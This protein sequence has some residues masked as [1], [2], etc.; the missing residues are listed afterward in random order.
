MRVLLR[1]LIAIALLTSVASLVACSSGPQFKYES[2]R[3][4]KPL[5]DK[6]APLYPAVSFLVFS[7]LHIY[8]ATL[9]IEGQAFED[10]LADD[11]KLL[12]ESL[13]I[14]ESA[15][16]AMKAE[17]ADFVIVPGDLSKD[18]ELVSHETCATYLDSLEASG[19]QVFVVPGNHDIWNGNAVRYT[20]NQTER[21]PS[22]SP[23]DF[24]RIYGAYGYNEALY[25]DTASL[26]Y[27]VEPED[28][29]WL[30]ALD[31]CIYS[32][33]QEAIGPITDG[34]FKTATLE[35]IEDMLIK[36]LQ[37]NKAVIAILHHGVV[38]HF[39]G[40]D[41]YYGE[42]V[43][44]D[45]EAVARLLATYNVRI[46]FTG[47]YHAQ[48]IT[49]RRLSKDG[50]FI[51][52]IETGSL[53]TYPDPYRVVT[54]SQDQKLSVRSRHVQKIDGNDDFEEYALSY[55]ESGIR[56]IATGAIEGYGVKEPAAEKMAE[57]VARAF[58]AHYAGDENLPVGQSILNTSGLGFRA[59]LVATF[60]RGLVYGLW[61]DLEPPDNNV[62]IDLKTVK[63]Q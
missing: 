42:Y 53:V 41:K 19:K 60:R 58:V 14:L 62:T 46:A 59:W 13:K 39:E 57:Q 29:L 18:G 40:Q 16:D 55:I 48:D 1:C 9:G 15:I 20:G 38:E 12:R 2:D 45:F 52:D 36:A 43:L 37:Q 49:L 34:V 32:K 23:E 54:I 50:K 22:V 47:H 28:G 44:D 27:V 11:R 4:L 56:G 30:L 51:F 17:N 6:E 26:S 31:S 63:W 10:Y 8:P 25:R 61:H 35:W 24:A 21:V 7:D 33:E 5:L 3:S